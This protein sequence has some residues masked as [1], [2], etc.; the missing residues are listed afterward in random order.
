MAV[1]KGTTPKTSGKTAAAATKA[2]PGKS[3]NPAKGK[4]AGARKAPS[5]KLSDAQIRVL[6]SVRAAG[7]GGYAP[8]KGEA[9]TLS[10]LLGKKLVKRG[11][12][13]D[14]AARYLITKAGDKHL[15]APAAP[16]APST[17]APAP[18]APAMPAPAP[19]V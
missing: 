12:K 7:E 1:K 4:P 18:E 5:I 11:K 2:T 9:S 19:T 3:T 10:S 16:A 6:G 8:G 13:V 14:G 15:G 17:P